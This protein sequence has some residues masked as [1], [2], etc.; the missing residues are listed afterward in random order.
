MCAVADLLR[1]IHLSSR[2]FWT[3]KAGVRRPVPSVRPRG[4]V[5]IDIS[6]VK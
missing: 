3:D 1:I 6:E 4:P 2:G 5:N